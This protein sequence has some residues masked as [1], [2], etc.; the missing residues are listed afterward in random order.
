MG[1]PEGAMPEA[2]IDVL[3]LEV[4]GRRIGLPASLVVEVLPSAA[5]EPLPD[6]PAAVEGVLNVRGEVLPVI[7]MR[8]RLGMPPRPPTVDDH[9]VRVESGGR[10]LLLRVDRALD[11]IGVD[12]WRLR[13][14]D[15]A[16]GA[17]ATP[18]GTLVVQDAERFLTVEELETLDL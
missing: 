3:L 18:E 12:P 7:S 13:E 17:V 15:A 1:Y 11:L 16:R 5:V 8:H 10:H 4:D 14:L 6:A 2:L 9:L